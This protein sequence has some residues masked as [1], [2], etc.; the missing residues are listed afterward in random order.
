MLQTKCLSC[1]NTIQL[2]I[3][4]FFTFSVT[5]LFILLTQKDVSAQNSGFCFSSFFISY[6]CLIKSVYVQSMFS[7]CYTV[8]CCLCVKVY[9][10]SYI[11]HCL[12]LVNYEVSFKLSSSSFY[13][14]YNYM[15]LECLFFPYI[16]LFVLVRLHRPS[17]MA[18]VTEVYHCMKSSK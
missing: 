4:K 9:K 7:L 16:P 15:E 10:C 6:Y 12:W 11:L 17:G 18:W 1:W 14:P 13:Q 3:H 5:E 2:V 8:P